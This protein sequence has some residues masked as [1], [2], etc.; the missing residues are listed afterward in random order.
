VPSPSCTSPPVQNNARMCQGDPTSVVIEGN[1]QPQCLSAK[2]S[3]CKF[4][5][6]DMEQ[7]DFD[8]NMLGCGGTWAAPLWM[9]PNRWKGGGASGEVDMMENCPSSAVYSNFAG[10][11]DQVRWSFADPNNLR[12]HTT[13]WKR[14]DSN[15][16]MSVFVKTC[17]PSE[18]VSGSCAFGGTMAYLRDIYG[19]NGCSNGGDCIYTLI[20]DIWNGFSGDGGYIGCAGGQPHYSSGCSVA[21][22]RI[23]FKAA[24]GTFLGNCAALVETAPSPTPSPPSPTPPAPSPPSPM[25]S[26]TPGTWSPCSASTAVCCNPDSSPAQICPGGQEC[27]EC[28]GG[29]ACE[30]PSSAARLLV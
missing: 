4:S 29:N 1:G 27:Q 25:P 10:G 14:A 13:M 19:L 30:C 28:G 17:Q 18:L 23:R 11:G 20:S 12:S 6:Y 21:V 24:A 8:V 16:V 15:G 7:L 2:A 26:P 3:D 9:S 5:M 22:S